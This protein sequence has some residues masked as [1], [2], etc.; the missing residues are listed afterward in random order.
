MAT[1]RIVG[2]PGTGKTT[3][4]IDAAVTYIR[5]GGDPESVLMLTGWASFLLSCFVIYT[6]V[7]SFLAERFTLLLAEGSKTLGLPERALSEKFGT[8]ALASVT[9]R[10]MVGLE[11][12]LLRAIK[13]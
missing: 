8:A 5:G 12:L 13:L 6:T 11:A 1:M 4:L 2:G 9:Q 3:R 10:T 7:L